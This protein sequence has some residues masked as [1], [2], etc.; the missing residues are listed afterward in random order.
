MAIV[1]AAPD[2]YM[3]DHTENAVLHYG[4]L[5]DGMQLLGKPFKREQFARKGAEALGIDPERV[6]ESIDRSSTVID[7]NVRRCA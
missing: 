3:S 2:F 1:R 7:L 6:M 4:C 5:E